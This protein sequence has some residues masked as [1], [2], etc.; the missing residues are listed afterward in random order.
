MHSIN[1]ASSSTRLAQFAVLI[2][3]ASVLFAPHARADDVGGPGGESDGGASAAPELEATANRVAPANANPA[4]TCAFLQLR[5]EARYM[6]GHYPAAI[7]DLQGALQATVGQTGSDDCNEW[8]IRSTLVSA[9]RDSG[10]IDAEIAFLKQSIQDTNAERIGQLFYLNVKLAGQYLQMGLFDDATVAIS[11]AQTF[12]GTLQRQKTWAWQG[13][14]VEAALLDFKAS[15]AMAQGRYSESTALWRQT[16]DEERAFIV[17]QRSRYAGDS[18]QVRSAQ[19]LLA[20]RERQLAASLAAEGRLGEAVLSG[21]AAL[22]ETLKVSGKSTLDAGLGFFMLA[23]IELR[24]GNV[25]QAYALLNSATERLQS[26]QIQPYSW[27][28]ARVRAW[29][30]LTLSIQHKWE[31]AAEVYR[32]RN[33]DLRLSESQLSA[34]GSGN[35]DWAMALTRTGQPGRAERMLHDMLDARASQ[36]RKGE[37]PIAYLHGYLGVALLEQNRNDAALAEFASAIPDLLR[38]STDEAGS[39]GDGAFVRQFRLNAIY[40]A[41]LEALCRSTMP[42]CAI[43]G[44]AAQNAFA[45]ADAARNSSVQRAITMSVARARLPDAKLAQLARTEQDATHRVQS[46]NRL[47]EHVDGL[48]NGNEKARALVELQRALDRAQEDNA[49][50]K[51]QLDRQFPDYR[52]L[53][54]PPPVHITDLQ[55]LL[56]SDE[57][58]VCIFVGEQRTY[59]WTI[60]GNASRL[61]SIQVGRQQIAKWVLDVRASVDLEGKRLPRFDVGDAS[62]LYTTLLAPD[63]DLW[64]QARV[65]DVLPSGPLASLPFG[66]LLT[67]RQALPPASVKPNYAQ[68]PWLIDRTAIAQYPSAG[69]FVALRTTN[70]SGAQRWPFVGFGAPVFSA[71]E[72]ARPDASRGP[73]PADETLSNAQETAG[74]D[75]TDKAGE[76]G[77]LDDGSLESLVVRRAAMPSAVSADGP[78]SPDDRDDESRL[79]ASL[80]ARLPS[81]PD[82]AQELNEIATVLG[83]SP[84]RDL[85]LGARATVDNVKTVDLS[86]YRVIEFATHGIAPGEVVGFDEPA[87]ILSNPSLVNE[88]GNGL[89]ELDDVLSLKLD[90]DWVVLSACNTGSGNVIGAEAV[91]GLGRAFLYAGSRSLMVSN[92]SVETVSA[93][94]LTT[95]VFKEQRDHPELGRAQT[96]RAAELDV[97]RASGG[98]YQHPAFWSAFSL[99]GDG[100]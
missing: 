44:P 15:A 23:Q 94:M 85:F 77:H 71:K 13:H 56:K 48:N 11:Q 22:M 68:M 33:R 66:L 40:E 82:T 39:E 32:L 87:L 37:L 5:G 91:S 89:L 99:V 24:Q 7:D 75:D 88:K 34:H 81:L 92:W 35:I 51:T 21:R 10:D 25:P 60:S 17:Q 55:R 95:N 9:Y 19:M 62:I 46:L 67:E 93:R 3:V 90:A 4:E 49:A 84:E 76:R 65:L 57:F 96:L 50:S 12:A 36:S 63:A 53:V 79:Q 1:R 80:Y 31:E 38:D 43:D 45:V 59:V 8:R 28:I 86:R 70:A 73:M 18:V 2:V 26:A 16:L 30:G 58:A 98:R 6:T 97:M 29:I 78:A 64:A 72:F 42:A 52:R 27:Q 83:A 54:D 61:R 47:L 14:E 20:R 41:Y 74:G 100:S 69:A